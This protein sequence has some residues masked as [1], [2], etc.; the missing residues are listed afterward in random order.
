MLSQLKTY[1][2][3]LNHFE[4]PVFTAWPK[5][6]LNDIPVERKKEFKKKEFTKYLW[7]ILPRVDFFGC[8]KRLRLKVKVKFFLCLVHS[9]MLVWSP[10]HVVPATHDLELTFNN[11]SEPNDFTSGHLHVFDVCEHF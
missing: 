2:I 6:P 11:T 7:I 3:R 5:F 10:V 9:K 8:L 1:H 4:L